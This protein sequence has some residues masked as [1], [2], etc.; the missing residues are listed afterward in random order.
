V[1]QIENTKP[2]AP[3]LP[4]PLP[5]SLLNDLLYCPRRAAL[6]ASENGFGPL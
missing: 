1:S 3:E 2:Q 4:D 5:L 6:K